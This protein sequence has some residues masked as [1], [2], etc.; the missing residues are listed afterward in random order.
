M[1]TTGLRV[2]AL[3]VTLPGI[4]LGLSVRFNRGE[5]MPNTTSSS[6]SDSEQRIIRELIR[7]RLASGALKP[8]YGMIVSAPIATDQTC[9]GCGLPIASA[10]AT[11]SR[12]QYADGF[13]WFHV[14]CDALWEEERK[15]QIHEDLTSP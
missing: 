13:Q 9:A 3:G 11:R 5:P 12:H 4:W 15:V 14:V 6:D 10:E 2:D 8:Y 1:P 7:A